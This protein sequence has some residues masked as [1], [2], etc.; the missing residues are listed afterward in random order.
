M[1][2]ASIAEAMPEMKGLFV[3][4]CVERGVGSRF[5][6]QAHAHTTKGDPHEGWICVLSQRRLFTS[7]GEP[8]R[9]MWH[10]YAHILTGHGHDDVW[11][12]KMRELGQPLPERYKRRKRGPSS[13]TGVR[14]RN[15]VVQGVRNGVVLWEKAAHD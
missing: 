10:E 11:R 4:G 7:K 15:G 8:S 5:R 6:A 2:G 13:F 12:A 3:G 9:L 1:I 14:S